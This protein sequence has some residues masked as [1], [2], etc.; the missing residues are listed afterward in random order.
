MRKILSGL[1]LC[2]GLLPY[3]ANS[4]PTPLRDE[5]RQVQEQV[6]TLDKDVVI[7][8]EITDNR[9]DA[10]DKRI[11][12]LGLSIAQQANYMAAIS[13]STTLVGALI[14]LI[15][16]IAGFVVYFTAR[17]RAAAEARIVAKEEARDAAQKLFEAEAASLQA[18]MSELRQKVTDASQE[19][20]LRKTE[21]NHRAARASQEIDRKVAQQ[22]LSRVAGKDS[23]S[24]PS[25]DPASISAV[26][27]A[28]QALES[29]PEKAF[30]SED[31]YAR[32]LDEYLATRF[33]SALLNFEK[34]LSQAETESIS[35]ERRIGLMLARAVTLGRL[36]RGQDAISAYDEIDQCYGADGAPALREQVAGALVNK[37]VTFGQLGR[38]E[39]EIAAYD[40][41]ERRYSADATPA[42]RQQVASALFNK[43]FTLGQLGRNEDEIAAYDEIE[44]RYSADDTPAL[45]Q[46]VA[47]ALVNK[48]VTLGRLGRSKDEIAVYDEIERRYNADENPTLHE[49]IA[50][51][52][53]NKGVRLGL[54]DRGEDEIAVYDKIDH[55]YGADSSLAL[56]EQVASALVNKALRLGRNG[57]NKEAMEVY[58]EIDQRYGGDDSPALRKQV[59]KALN[60]RAFIRIL[61]AKQFWS[62]E[63]KRRHLLALALKDLRRIQS[64]C[65]EADQ[66]VFLGN[67]GYALFLS[68][69]IDQA[70]EPTRECLRLG[71]EES[72]QA[73]RGDAQLHRVEPQD[74]DYEK[75]LDRLWSELHPHT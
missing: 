58:V 66:A 46:L 31:H 50:R 57:R 3:A 51:A 52:L 42:L 73:Q 35:P 63:I 19:I 16:L 10:Q 15:A 17:E 30:T 20:E 37:G 74:S 12:D 49:L 11:G 27:E 4:A 9:L 34:A 44:R 8:K 75:L 25:P 1:F 6:R 56:R 48:G 47:S 36:N 71:G 7:L 39:D 62:T 61:Q 69:E 33:D 13:N 65:A 14:T 28:S 70:E 18:Q 43:G 54:L 64:Q 5:V 32:G 23:A 40:E 67:L 41:I 22:I 26:R 38:S 55:R 2:L 29:K 53:V 24:E 72:L 60:C 68:G 21:V 45:R 59:A